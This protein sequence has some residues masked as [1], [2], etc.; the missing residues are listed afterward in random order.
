LTPTHDLRVTDDAAGQFARTYGATAGAI[1]VVR[2][3]GCLG[4]AS[5][6]PA[7]LRPDALIEYL[8]NTFG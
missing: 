5:S 6:E 8:H 7:S 1:F 2:P 3:D 4:F